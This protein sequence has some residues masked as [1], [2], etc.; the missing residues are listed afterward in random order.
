MTDNPALSDEEAA[1]MAAIEGISVWEMIGELL[2]VAARSVEWQIR[3]RLGG[4]GAIRR[5]ASVVAAF[6]AVIVAL[7]VRQCAVS[8]RSLATVTGSRT[9]RH[10]RRPPQG[11][12]AP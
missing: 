12:A 4:P 10:L 1:A 8:T 9:L 6:I 5:L 11:W 7:V 2:A 3:R